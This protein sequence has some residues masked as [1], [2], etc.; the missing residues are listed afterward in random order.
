MEERRNE[1]SI[2]KIVEKEITRTN[3]GSMLALL[4]AVLLASVGAFIYAVALLEAE[5]YVV[6]GIMLGV[7]IVVFTVVVILFCG[8]HIVNPNEAIVLTLFGNYYGTIRKQGFYH[9]NP[10]CTAINPAGKTHVTTRNQTGTITAT[11]SNKKISTKVMTLNNDK[12]KVNDVVGNPLV[13]GV[14]AIWKVEDPTKAVFNVENYKSYLSIQCDSTIRNI[15]R[16]YP[17]DIMEE[18]EVDEK[19]LRGSSQEIAE[20]MTREL[21]ERVVDAGLKIIEVRITHLSY[22]EEIAASMLQRQQAV[23]VI[24]ARKKIVEGAVSMVKMAI[25]E[26]SAEEVVVLDEERKAAMVS[27][28]LVVLCGNKDAQPI[29]NSGS[30]Y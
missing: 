1:N 26:L 28:L 4:L 22:A 30:I 21:Q 8:L 27:N 19:T 13:I 25:D 20:R 10:F 17:Y 29:V 2:K 18:D 12:Q 5:T 3:G 9:V 11:V 7:S 14:V 24:A 23:A 15:A 6:G 16:L